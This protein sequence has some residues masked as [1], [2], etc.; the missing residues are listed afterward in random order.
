MSDGVLEAAKWAARPRQY[1]ARAGSPVRRYAGIGF[2][3]LL[4]I[5]FI[6]ALMNGLATRVVQIIQKPVEVR[7]I[8]QVKPVVPPP[9]P[10][11][12]LAPPKPVPPRPRPFVPRPE[13]VVT[14][15]PAPVISHQA[16]PIPTPVAPPPAPLAPVEAPAPAKPVSHEAGVVCPN[17]DAVR[18]SMVYPQEAQDNNITGDVVISFVVDTQ[19][20]VT[21]EKVEQ[22]A[23][24]VL[25]RAAFNTVKKFNCVSQ[26][27]AVRVRVPFSFNL[28]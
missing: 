1:G 8:E 16:A 23:D 7:I 13:V 26:G 21:D 19:G 28:N 3:L 17:S 10:V 11:V 18:R 15:P 24:P 2:V 25:N 27:E 9:V 5:I 12:K 20:H 22:A 14:P 6:W 4:H